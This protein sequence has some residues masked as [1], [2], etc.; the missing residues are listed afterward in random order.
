MFDFSTRQW[1][2]LP[3]IPSKRVFAMYTHNHK[4]LFS[5]GGLNQP[6]SQ[7]FSDVFEIFDIDKGNFFY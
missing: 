7:G 1:Q 6:A 2:K 3:G 4:N 5:I